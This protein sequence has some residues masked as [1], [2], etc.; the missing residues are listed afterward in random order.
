MTNVRRKLTT[1][2]AVAMGFEAAREWELARQ[3]EQ[4]EFEEEQEKSRRKEEFI[5]PLLQA[6]ISERDAEEAYKQRVLEDGKAHAAH[7]REAHWRARMKA[8]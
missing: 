2:E 8:V 1:D 3:A 5:A 7:T 6:G 4:A